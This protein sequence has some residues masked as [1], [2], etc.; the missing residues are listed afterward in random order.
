MVEAGTLKK[1]DYV[2]YD[3]APYL[4]VARGGIITGTHSHA[5]TKLEI[6]SIFTGE[7]R[8]LTMPDSE[9]MEIADIIR[10]H[11]QLIAKTGEGEGQVMD[12]RDFSVRDANIP[13]E[14]NIHEGDEI[15]FIEFKGKA[16][17]LGLREK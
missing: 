15:T 4:V 1:G 14:L 9:D 17:I 11:G 3:G 5:K 12:M 6:L 8:V 7:K 10:K 16:Q 2:V 13:K